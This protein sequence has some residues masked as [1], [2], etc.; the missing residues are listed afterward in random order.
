R[1]FFEE[2]YRRVFQTQQAWEHTYECSSAEAFR[3]YRMM[4]CPHT[5]SNGIVVVNSL[6]LEP[7][8]DPEDRRRATAVDSDYAAEEGY[9]TM[10]SHCRRT[11]RLDGSN[12]DWVPE[13]V[14][15]PPMNVTHGICG[16]CVNLFYPDYSRE[17]I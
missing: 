11:A 12:W 16:V 17:L 15:L 1:P 5:D 13:F 6:S 2:K 10:C 14:L 7:A 3:L 4:V 8:H 9:L